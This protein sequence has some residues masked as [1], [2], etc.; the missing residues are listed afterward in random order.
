MIRHRVL[1]LVLVAAAGLAACQP[2]AVNQALPATKA[3]T[4]PANIP[5]AF[6]A[7]TAPSVATMATWWN[8]SPYTVVGIYVGG[9]DR[10]CPQPNLT[11]TWVDA[12]VKQGW[13]LIPIWV[14]PQAP[15]VTFTNKIPTDAT[16]ISAG[17]AEADAAINAMQ[18][19]GLTTWLTPIYYDLEAYKLRPSDNSCAVTDAQRQTTM[20]TAVRMFINGWTYELHRHGLLSGLYSSLCSAITDESTIPNVP[21]FGLNPPDAVWIASWSGVPNI[22]GFSAV[23]TTPPAPSCP[24]LPDTVWWN[25]KRIHQFQ[26]G[27]DETWPPPQGLTIPNSQSVTINV[28][29]SI[30]DGPL[31]PP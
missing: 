3:A 17:I 1:A 21:D 15:C 26:G 23:P 18:A 2:V 14:G 13:R 12:V 28:D 6:D 4:T 27:H 10:L 16:A 31:A 5:Q 7:C 29:T 30:V 25:H 9:V 22:L 19:L 8:H 20:T 24:A 11:K